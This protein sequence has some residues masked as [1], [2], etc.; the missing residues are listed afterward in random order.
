MILFFF[1]IKVSCYEIKREKLLEKAKERYHKCG[2]KEKAAKNYEINQGF[3]REKAR[4]QYRNLVK[5]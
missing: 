5:R 3:L 2:G 4:H 1:Y